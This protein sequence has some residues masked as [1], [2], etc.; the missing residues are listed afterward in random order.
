MPP[1]TGTEPQK[2]DTPESDGR[3]KTNLPGRR[4]HQ[5]AIK[6][7]ALTRPSKVVV[8]AALMKHQLSETLEENPLPGM[9]LAGV[10]GHLV[11]F[12]PPFGRKRHKQRSCSFLVPL[13]KKSDILK[14]LP[15]LHVG[16]DTVPMVLRHVL[17][18]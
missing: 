6:L 8:V 1:K 17:K 10:T 7:P 9:N 3:A 12:A 5:A 11:C 4:S 13:I 2:A 15:F 14:H 16:K 18:T